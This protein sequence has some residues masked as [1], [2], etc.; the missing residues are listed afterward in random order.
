LVFV[1]FSLSAQT[2]SANYFLQ[3]GLDEKQKGRRMESLRNF[4]KAAKYDSTNK[5]LEKELASAYLDLRKYY[6]AKE[7]YKR[8]VNLGDATS[9]N[10]KQLLVLCFNLQNYDEALIY[11]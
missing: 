2:D 4:E 6:Q 5:V 9:A 1:S 7:T 10:F 11:A 3:K 8:L